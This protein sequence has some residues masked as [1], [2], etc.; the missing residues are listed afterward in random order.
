MH[1]ERS[2]RWG[3]S[4]IL[5]GSPPGAALIEVQSRAALRPGTTE[6]ATK[7]ASIRM[8]HMQGFNL[9]PDS[10]KCLRQTD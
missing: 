3:L 10:H 8:Q 4:G 7:P 6:D 9:A 1:N 2:C 5:K